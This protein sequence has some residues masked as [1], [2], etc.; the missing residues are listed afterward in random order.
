[1]KFFIFYSNN[2]QYCNKLLKIIKD[3]KLNEDC[4]LICFESNPDKIPEFITNV[5]TI[6]AQNLSKPLVGLEA[7]EWI[8]NKKYFNQTTNNIKNNNVINPNIQSALKEYE[9]NKQEIMSISDH[10]TN[11]NDTQIEKILMDCNNINIPLLNNNNNII[12]E[13][14]IT[15]DI[16]EQK[17]RELILLR[18]HQINSKLFDISKIKS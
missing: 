3:E 18:K 5:P 7:V 12:T 17:L 10:Y 15:N 11:I 14:K 13:N 8:I 2:C 1:M 16:Q 4:Q 9:F 6:I